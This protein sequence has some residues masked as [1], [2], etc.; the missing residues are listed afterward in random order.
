M[1]PRRG[2]KRDDIRKGLRTVGYKRRVTIAFSIEDG[3]VVIHGVFYGGQDV[4]RHLSDPL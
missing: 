4:E 2:M 3:I 1:F